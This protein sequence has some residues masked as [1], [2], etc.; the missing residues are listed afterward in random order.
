F[1]LAQALAN[2][3]VP[4]GDRIAIVTNAG[5]PGILCTDAVIGAGL[6]LAELQPKTREALARALPP[7]ASTGNPVDMIASADAKSYRAALELVRRDKGV[8]GVIAIF[9][10][11]IMIDAYE[12]AVAIAGA[13][14]GGKPVLSVFMG[15]QRSDEGIAWLR[16]NR[17]PVYRF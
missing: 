7:E 1:T 10:S 2:Q 12:V 13:A 5:G 11:P 6:T 8:D 17:V 4:V 3:P 15:K 14:D 16:R 9:V